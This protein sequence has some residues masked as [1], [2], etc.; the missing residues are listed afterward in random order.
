MEQSLREK[1]AADDTTAKK[2][3]VVSFFVPGIVY[4]KTVR[5]ATQ[6]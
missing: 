4:T 2:F 6:I 5:K 1:T 3:G